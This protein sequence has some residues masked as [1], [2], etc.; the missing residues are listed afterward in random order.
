MRTSFF[1][2][3]ITLAVLVNVAPVLADHAS[4]GMGVGTA[5]SINTESGVTLPKGRWSTG[6]RSEY[7]NF[8]EFSESK[9]IRLREEDEDAD[10]HNVEYLWSTAA[11]A[12]YGVTDDFTVGVRIPY[13][14]RNNIREPG[15][16]H[17]HDEG[18][19]DDHGDEE[20]PE[21]EQLGDAKGLG[22]ISLFGQYRFYKNPHSRHAS[23]LLGLK[24][25][26][27]KRND[28]SREGERFEQ[29]FQPGSGSWDGMAG[30]AYTQFLGSF[31]LDTSV[32]Y[33]LVTEGSQ[34]TD[35]GDVFGYNLGLAYRVGGG[36]PSAFYADP[37]GIAVDLVLEANG[38]WRAKEEVDNDK[39]GN[40]G[41]NVVYLS[42]GIRLSGKSNWSLF[43]SVGLP[44]IKNFNGDQTEPDYRIIGGL[45]YGF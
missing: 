18:G 38:E 10:L 22:D 13:V 3:V 42:P 21:I 14:H 43:G 4:V 41:G 9:L 24:A 37:A 11:T 33:T 29:E 7:I 35:L 5:A 12:F 16:G 39:D 36:R 15:H 23:V 8:D 32:M 1:T 6:V 27:G 25:P 28:K 40:S 45:A 31:A 34:D 26:T 44:V 17:G 2:S 30:L 19:D 20:A